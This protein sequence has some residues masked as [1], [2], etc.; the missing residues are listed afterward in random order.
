M[1]MDVI[2][3]DVFTADILIFGEMFTYATENAW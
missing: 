1:S 3:L 2:I